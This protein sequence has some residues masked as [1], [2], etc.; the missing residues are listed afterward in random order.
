MWDD[1]CNTSAVRL[2]ANNTEVAEWSGYFEMLDDRFV[3]DTSKVPPGEYLITI[4]VCDE[5]G[6][7]GTYNIGTVTVH[8]SPTI[9]A[10]QVGQFAVVVAG[11]VSIVLVFVI[12]AIRSEDVRLVLIVLVV[13]LIAITGNLSGVFGPV[14]LINLIS[15]VCGLISFAY[16][17][18]N[19]VAKWRNEKRRIPKHDPTYFA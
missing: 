12:I 15:S 7:D 18:C 14:E 4:Y 5:V 10:K 3:W 16:A 19:G 2:Y 6:N 1:R 11:F 13:F 8:R 17:L 9:G